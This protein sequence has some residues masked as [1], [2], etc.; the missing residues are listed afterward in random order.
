METGS[1]GR[2]LVVRKQRLRGARPMVNIRAT[3]SLISCAPRSAPLRSRERRL[4]PTA[5]GSYRRESPRTGERRLQATFVDIDASIFRRLSA[6]SALQTREKK[7]TMKNLRFLLAV[8][9]PV[10]A[11]SLGAN[12][13][14][15]GVSDDKAQAKTADGKQTKTTDEAKPKGAELDKAAPDFTLKDV[16]GKTVKLSDF[17]GK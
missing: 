2:K 1:N 11:L 14:R 17:K 10:I 9:V 13:M 16:D 12:A 6:D 7:R 4:E 8:A 3:G 15:A 5:V